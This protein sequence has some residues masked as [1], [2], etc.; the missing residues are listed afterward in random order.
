[1]S[2][3]DRFDEIGARVV[4]LERELAAARDEHKKAALA[5]HGVSIGATV[6]SIEGRHYGKL[7]K[8]VGVDWVYAR[9]KP[10][11]HVHPQKK[12]GTFALSTIS[13]FDAWQAV[14]EPT[15][16]EEMKAIVLGQPA[17]RPRKGRTT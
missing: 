1:M 15:S 2:D 17:Q 9:G 12:D 13:L 8:V 4:H 5:L 14:K 3:Q 6:R 7:F 11:L 16:Y 10:R